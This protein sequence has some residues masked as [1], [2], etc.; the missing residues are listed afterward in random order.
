MII[1]SPDDSK[2]KYHV[3]TE[4]AEGSPA[5]RFIS[6][7]EFAAP[8][9]PLS[10]DPL[11]GYHWRAA[12]G[13]DGMQLFQSFPVSVVVSDKS[14]F[15]GTENIEPGK[16]NVEV[17]G[18]GH[19][20]F[21]FGVEFAGWLEIESPD[22][23]GAAFV[24]LGVSEYNLPGVV[25]RGAQSPSKLSTP[26]RVCGSVYRLELN[27]ELYEGV[28][29]GFIL[30]N[31]V[32][33]PFH[34]TGVRLICQVKPVNYPGS[35]SSGDALLDRIWYTAAYTVRV[36]LR[37]D[38]FSAILMERGDRFSWTGDAYPAQ[39]AALYAFGNYDFVLEN[40]RYTAA[41]SNGIETYELYWVLSLLDYYTC[42]GDREG[43][44]SLIPEA[45]KR[46]DRAYEIRNSKPDLCFVGWDERLG[47][48]FENPNTDANYLSY[49]LIA[50]EAFKRIAA[51]LEWIDD[52][53]P[54]VSVSGGAG[55]DG[56]G[57]DVKITADHAGL[58][59]AADLATLARKY[60]SYA[61][62]VTAEVQALSLAE[63]LELH[64]FCDLVNAGLA[65]HALAAKLFRKFFGD[66]GNRISYSPFNEYFILRALASLSKHADAVSSVKDLYGGQLWYGGTCFFE[67]FRPDWL[68]NNPETGTCPPVPNSQ[69]GYTS[70]SHPWGSGVL[71][72]LSGEILGVKPDSPG[73]RTF[74]VKPRPELS[75]G[76]VS[77]TV[78]T[79]FGTV[80]VNADASGSLFV[81]VPE[82]TR[83]TVA[84]R[85]QAISGTTI[86][87]T[88]IPGT[89]IPGAAAPSQEPVCAA[90]LINGHPASPSFSD[91]THLYFRD[92]P[93]GEYTFTVNTQQCTARPRAGHYAEPT[94]RYKGSFWGFYSPRADL[95]FFVKGIYYC[96]APAD[97]GLNRLPD[98]VSDVVL[99]KGISLTSSV[100]PQDERLAASPFYRRECPGTVTHYATDF[101]L[102]TFQTFTVD[103]ILSEER[104]F[105]AVLYFVDWEREEKRL[106]VEMFDLKTRELVAPAK[107]LLNYEEGVYMVYAYNR[108][109]RFR[110]NHVRGSHASLTGILFG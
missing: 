43:F 24:R 38:Y 15:K 71:N 94:W 52:A 56:A 92:L 40:L 32:R 63:T 81:S 58:A 19:L 79:P 12:S 73:F 103:V 18:D 104:P 9:N 97:A 23:E 100:D 106:A 45:V 22:L 102:P 85:G 91:A 62:E 64:S 68:M 1:K 82:G 48:G 11:L 49:K 61:R 10:Q 13:G 29:F 7:G 33:R 59:D 3:S 60:N 74:S 83:A 26:T 44:E 2:Y 69:A 46:L 39:A 6:G 67:V 47:A 41:H 70:L 66:R 42:S 88:T 16:M 96:G 101:D 89:T 72:W 25:N 107:M 77:G 54:E 87:G 80:K 109:C 57:P 36:N 90:V 34:I 31:E 93:G 75:G 5:E 86:S 20:I 37:K 17:T 105:N 95:S 27:N 14:I 28:R 8:Q 108:S 4:P 35:F 84:I 30:V 76:S 21:D 78:P 98:Y 50:V 99:S 65:D 110:V 51:A 55:L 53:G